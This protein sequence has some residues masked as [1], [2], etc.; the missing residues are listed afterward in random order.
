MTIF[1]TLISYIFGNNAEITKAVE[2]D[3][4]LDDVDLIFSKLN[5]YISE[6]DNSLGDRVQ[7][8]LGFDELQSFVLGKY[9]IYL[10]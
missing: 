1:T 2:K 4:K 3:V 8:E 7:R 10:I 9:S 5:N 6:A